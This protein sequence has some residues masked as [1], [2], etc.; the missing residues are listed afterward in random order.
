[1]SL[2]QFERD[3]RDLFAED[4]NARDDDLYDAT[5]R[6]LENNREQVKEIMHELYWLRLDENW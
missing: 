3:N 1:M 6:R 2:E 5:E 4:I